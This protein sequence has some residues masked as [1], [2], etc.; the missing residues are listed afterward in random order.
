M[1]HQSNFCASAQFAACAAGAQVLFCRWP[2]C[3]QFRV[4]VTD[5]KL[6]QCSE[7]LLERRLLATISRRNFSE[8]ECF[9]QRADSC[10]RFSGNEAAQ[11]MQPPHG[12]GSVAIWTERQL[13]FQRVRF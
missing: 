6:F 7:L 11:C 1:D 9:E 13:F 10:N 8:L 3:R 4:P 5:K 2:I 12:E